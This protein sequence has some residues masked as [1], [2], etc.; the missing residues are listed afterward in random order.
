MLLDKVTSNIILC[1]I[2]ISFNAIDTPSIIEGWQPFYNSNIESGEFTKAYSS[3][4]SIDYKTESQTSISGPS[5]KHKVI[6]R[7]PNSDN[8]RAERVA[9]LKKIKYVKLLQSNG[10]DIL[11]GR[12]DFFQ[13]TCPEIKT[14]MDEQLTQVEITSVSIMPPG[15][16][17]RFNTYGIPV[18]IPLNLI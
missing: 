3:I 10:L 17:P 15:Y 4:A 12:N 6:F 13:N 7:F 11:I 16:T 1:G 5:Y 8:F 18:L 9:L 2:E 14:T